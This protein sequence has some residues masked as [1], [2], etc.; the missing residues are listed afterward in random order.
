VGAAPSSLPPVA[1]P[2]PILPK[3]V[4]IVKTKDCTV[5]ILLNYHDVKAGRAIAIT[6]EE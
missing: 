2:I 3:N 4:T 5:E 6:T 1:S